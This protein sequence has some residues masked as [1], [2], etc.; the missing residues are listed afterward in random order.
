VKLRKKLI[1]VALLLE[2]ETAVGLLGRPPRELGIA[3]RL[4]YAATLAQPGGPHTESA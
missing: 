4:P 3:N 1:E 2:R